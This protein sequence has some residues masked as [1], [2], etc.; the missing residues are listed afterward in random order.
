MGRRGN[1]GKLGSKKHLHNQ[2]GEA[3]DSTSIMQWSDLGASQNNNRNAITVRLIE[4]PTRANSVDM[5]L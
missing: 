3:K 1:K 2:P 4:L 5:A